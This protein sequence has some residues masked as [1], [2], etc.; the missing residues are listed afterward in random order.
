MVCLQTMNGLEMESCWYI[1]GPFA[2]CYGHLVYFLFR[3]VYFS[4]FG[5]LYKDI[6]G[7]TDP[8]GYLRM[9]VFEKKSDGKLVG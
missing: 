6:S 2:L 8:S 4:R 5:M 3:L 1:L 7:N 9:Q